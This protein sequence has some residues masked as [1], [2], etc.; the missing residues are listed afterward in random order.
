M[1]FQSAFRDAMPERRARSLNGRACV[2]SKN[3]EGRAF[4]SR[5]REKR[6]KRAAS[7]TGSA[8]AGGGMFSPARD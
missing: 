1:I 7:T 2:K 4:F 5:E 6:E 3:P 8:A